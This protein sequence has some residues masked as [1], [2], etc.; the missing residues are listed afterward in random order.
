M[1]KF[2]YRLQNI[3]DIKLKLENQAKTN[4]ATAAANV[5][6]EEEQLN[7]IY[8]EQKEYMD[9]YRSLTVGKLD[10]MELKHMRDGV[11]SFK[12]RIQAQKVRLNNANKAL[13]VARF[14]LNEAMKD[15]KT[16]EKLKDNAF[17]Q[18]KLDINASEKKEIDELVSFKYN[19][20]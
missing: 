9:Q 8:T 10:V 2:V 6:A 4:F 20:R 11:E 3:L 19:D 14:R 15:R 12:L 13:E 5:N 1:A 7:R 16:H 17:E 18:F